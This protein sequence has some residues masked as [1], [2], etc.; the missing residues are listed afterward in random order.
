MYLHQ[1]TT[2]STAATAT[3]SHAITDIQR[4]DIPTLAGYCVQQSE[5]FYRGHANDSR[6]A[7]EMFR[8]ALVERNEWAWQHLY[9]MY[10]PLVERWVRR[11]SA[12]TS[13]G[14]ASE[15]FVS[16]AFTRLWKAIGAE[17]FDSFPSL[18]SLLH[19][20][21][22]C[23]NC[24]VIDSVRTQSWA[25]MLPETLLAEQM[26]VSSPDEEAMDRVS[27][28][29]FWNCVN[30]QLNNDAERVVVYCSFILGMKPSEIVSRYAGQFADVKEVYSV[31]RNVLDRLSRNQELRVMLGWAYCGVKAA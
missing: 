27:R 28:E 12:F 5:R 30:A 20:L 14:E 10:S 19:Y 2:P 23:A 7:H 3:S 29:D 6:Y 17:R 18:A 9:A 21:Q 1:S 11:N 22:M 8:R 25:E 16:A 31:K 24:V 15:Y 26:L 13:S 4:M